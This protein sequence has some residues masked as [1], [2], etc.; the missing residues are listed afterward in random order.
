[1][2]Y[3]AIVNEVMLRLREDEVTSVSES[4]YSRLIGV[5]V[6]QALSEVEDARDWNV[7]RTTVQVTTAAGDYAYALASAG[8][9]YNILCVFNDT[10]DYEVCKAPSAAWMTHQLLG[11]SVEQNQPGHY[12]VNGVDGSGDPVVNFFPV[13]DAVYNINFNMKIK[14]VLSADTEEVYVDTL[15]VILKATLLAVDERGD[16]SGLTIDA[17]Q[18]QFNNA[19][20]N[21][22]AYDANL[23]EDETVWEVE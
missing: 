22:I 15:P 5:F 20:A 6:K 8:T 1:M 10:Q 9:S 17:L 7:L 18:G 23:N 19:L 13:P 2:N 11:P 4:S 3:L 21:A 16:D 12:D 14:T